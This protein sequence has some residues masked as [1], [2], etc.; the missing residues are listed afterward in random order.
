MVGHTVRKLGGG[1]WAAIAALAILAGAIG[2]RLWD[3]RPAPAPSAAD[4]I[5][6]LGALQRRAEEQPGSAEAWQ[7][8]GLALFEREQFAEAAAAYR[9]ATQADGQSAVLWSSLGEA[10]VMASDRDPMP[11]AARDAFHRA[12]TLDPKEPRTRYFLAVERD[13]GGDHA[14]AIDEWL[15]LLAVSPPTAP[16]S[17][18]LRRTIEQVGAIHSID[19]ADRLAA[20]AARQ[21]PPP[22]PVMPAIPGPSADQLAAAASLRPAEQQDMA[23]AMVA[24]LAARL[25]REPGNVEGWIMLMRSYRTLGRDAEARRALSTALANNPEAREQLQTAAVTLGVD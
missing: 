1:G 21:P 8:L 19:V 2:Y 18:D 6:P 11:A 14:G 15:A 10:L 24:R 12:R 13:L 17:A 7:Q 3:A 22:P 25:E 20:A 4:A 5:D 16:W 9:R 23:E